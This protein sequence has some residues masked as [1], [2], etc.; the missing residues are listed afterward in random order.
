MDTRTVIDTHPRTTRN[1]SITRWSQ[2]ARITLGA[3]TFLLIA[4]FAFA[5]V[6]TL[7]TP[8][9]MPMERQG[10]GPVHFLVFAGVFAQFLLILFYV[11]FAWQNPRT[12]NH[13]PWIVGMV[14]LPFATLP[15][16]WWVHVWK[17][18]Y[19]ADPHHDY[20]VPGGQLTP[21]A[22]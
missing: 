1:E 19:V 14:V 2:G 18:P 22:D 12:D 11:S 5:A 4:L 13:V 8:E 7:L 21:Q 16:Y 6:M 3:I 10:V 9:T 20:N 15:V 17:A